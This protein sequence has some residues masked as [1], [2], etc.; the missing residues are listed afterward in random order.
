MVIR[1]AV[2][3][4]LGNGGTQGKTAE[5]YFSE[6]EGVKRGDYRLLKWTVME[7]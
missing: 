5:I 1:R 7:D 4:Y 6:G 3:V 2:S